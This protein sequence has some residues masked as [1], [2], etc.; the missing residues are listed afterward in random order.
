MCHRFMAVIALTL[1]CYAG[2]A[3]AQSASRPKLEPI[4]DLQLQAFFHTPQPWQVK[5]HPMGVGANGVGTSNI[6]VCFVGPTTGCQ[7]IARDGFSS[8]NSVKFKMLAGP[9]RGTQR[10]VLVIR[11][12]HSAGTWNSTFHD[13]DVWTFVRF[14]GPRPGGS[15]VQIFHNA[16]FSDGEQE[17]VKSGLLAGAFVSVWRPFTVNAPVRYRIEAYEPTPSAYIRVLSLLSAKRYPSIN[18][19]LGGKPADQISVLM[20]QIVGVMRAAYP[21]G[22]PHSSM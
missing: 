15:F 4:N 12:T 6:R 10:P 17:F 20:P 11:T 7:T 2:A 13:V 3:V 21:G 9:R 18:T 16:C 8:L 1:L 14:G 19:N 22:P 5:I